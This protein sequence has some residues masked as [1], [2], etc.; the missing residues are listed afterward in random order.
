L[1]KLAREI[2]LENGL[3][4]SFYHHTHRYFGDYH[5]IKV[6][7][8]CEVPL[9]EEYFTNI[10]E[11]VEASAT[12]GG[13]AVF[14]RNLELMGVSS[15]EV[16]QSLENVI[17]NFSSHSLAYLASPLFPRKLI[18]AELSGAGRKLHKSGVYTG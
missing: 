9:L 17:D 5:R 3:T 10:A 14:R 15:A 16:E 2:S 12:L 18:L 13:K 4:V 11:F 8:I 7:I 1:I 6:E